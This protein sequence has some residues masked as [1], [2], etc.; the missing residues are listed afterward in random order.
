MSCSLNL[1]KAVNIIPLECQKHVRVIIAVNNCQLV[2]TPSPYTSEKLRWQL[3]APVE[4]A[5]EQ[6]RETRVHQRVVHHGTNVREREKS[7][8]R[9]L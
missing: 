2:Q 3:L 5:H 7:C 1:S 8:L 6:I 4:I 9:T